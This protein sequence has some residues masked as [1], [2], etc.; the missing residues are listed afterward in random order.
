[1]TREKI[2]TLPASGV[3]YVDT[4]HSQYIIDTDA[5]IATRTPLH[6][7]AAECERDNRSIRYGFIIC[8]VG[9]L[10]EFDWIDETGT[11]RFRRTTAVIG[12]TR[13]S[14]S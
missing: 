1:M 3:Y 9:T 11:R 7:D 14:Q 5:A 10:M 2:A 12:I 4:I 6:D 8:N 13:A